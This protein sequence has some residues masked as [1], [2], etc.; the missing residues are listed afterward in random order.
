MSVLDERL[1]A[2]V[3]GTTAK[4]LAADFGM[5]TVGDLLRHYPRRYGHRGELPDL[6]SVRDTLGDVADTVPGETR[7]RYKLCGLREALIGIHRPAD[8]AEAARARKRLKW[9]EAFLLQVALAQR[10]M[11]ADA[12]PAAPRRG[13]AGGLL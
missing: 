9:D 7:D 10:R 2:V 8:S 1:P 3:G 6:A 4:R 11:A 5:R 13:R 12:L